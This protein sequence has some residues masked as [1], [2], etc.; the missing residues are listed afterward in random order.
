MSQYEKDNSMP[1]HM[2]KHGG[3]STNSIAPLEYEDDECIV[4][5]KWRN[6]AG[7]MWVGRESWDNHNVS[8][9]YH[10]HVYNEYTCRVL[11]ANE[12]YIFFCKACRL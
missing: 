3:C 11:C 6:G 9:I 12:G 4:H 7:P 5:V 1:V 10:K 8:S 2:K